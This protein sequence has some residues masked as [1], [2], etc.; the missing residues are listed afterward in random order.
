MVIEALGVLIIAGGLAL[1]YEP[2]GLVAIGFY[3][4]VLAVYTRLRSIEQSRE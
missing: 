4:I 3:L 1:I 2:L